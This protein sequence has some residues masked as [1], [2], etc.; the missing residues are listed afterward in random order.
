M[1]DIGLSN[2]RLDLVLA[3]PENPQRPL[4]PIL[5]DGESWMKRTTVS[6]RD[7]LPIEVLEGLMGWPMVARIWWPMWLQNR[8]AVIARVLAEV[9]RAEEQLVTAESP[10]THLSDATPLPVPPVSDETE[11]ASTPADR[12][13]QAPAT[14]EPPSA[15]E[16]TAGAQTEAETQVPARDG[17]PI[18]TFQPAHTRVVGSV[19]VLDA[20]PDPAASAAV[21]EQ[22]LDVIQSEGPVELT[23]LLRIVARRFGLNTVRASR[24]EGLVR[25][26]P[27]SQLR[28][29][30]LGSFAWP[31][32]LDPATWTGFRR[33]DSIASRNVDEIAPEELRNAMRAVDLDHPGLGEEDLLRRTADVFGIT[34]LGARVRLRLEAVHENLRSESA[35][36]SAD[37]PRGEQGPTELSGDRTVSRG[38]PS[39]RPC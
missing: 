36:E 24:T 29:S 18:T 17:R 16:S 14:F 27:P 19:D 4:L 39:V 13:P 31:T 35:V 1:S 28:E 12:P 26:V 10:S 32:D 23:R 2:F 37:G 7:V 30:P 33:V 20:L 15:Q 6:D 21:H 3:R 11:T 22:V 9:D 34:R 8:D 5:L 38:D 25:L